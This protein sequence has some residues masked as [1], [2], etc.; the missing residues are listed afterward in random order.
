LVKKILPG[1][2]IQRQKKRCVATALRCARPSLIL[3]WGWGQAYLANHPAVVE[4]YEGLG[5]WV[6]V[7]SAV[8]GVLTFCD[9][10]F[11]QRAARNAQVI[12]AREAQAAAR[13]AERNKL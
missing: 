4:K 11:E 1:P 13:R 12:V 7:I 3:A 8:G 10:W 6:I 2:Q 5:L 9:P